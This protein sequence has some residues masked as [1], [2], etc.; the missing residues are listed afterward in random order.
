VVLVPVEVRFER[1]AGSAGG[2]EGGRAI[3]RATLLDAR[4]T[5]ARWVGDIQS[6]VASAPARALDSVAGRLADLFLTP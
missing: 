5:E 2:T 3:L 6:D 1:V 4:T